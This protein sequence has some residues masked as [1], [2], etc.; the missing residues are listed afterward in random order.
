M[1]LSVRGISYQQCRMTFIFDLTGFL[2]DFVTTVLGAVAIWGLF[3]R[4]K[5]ISLA[6]QMLTNAHLLHQINRIKETLGRL[7]ELT[8]DE[9]TER[10]KIRALMGQ[11]CGQLKPLS[12]KHPTL[13]S[14]IEILD[15]IMAGK[16]RLSESLKNQVI[17]Q[18][19]GELDRLAFD[20]H[21]AVIDEKD[22]EPKSN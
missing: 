19:H 12:Q 17:Y 6:F 1:R 3:F 13:E 16:K 9:K 14:S 10:T 4:R 5:Q 7:D 15:Q 18:I 21:K 2:S 11:I 8:F 22:D 20:N